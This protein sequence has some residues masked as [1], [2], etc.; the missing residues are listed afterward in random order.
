MIKV[1]VYLDGNEFGY[2]EF[3][4]DATI[5]DFIKWSNESKIIALTEY[6]TNKLFTIPITKY[7]VVVESLADE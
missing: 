5:Q 6:G 1:T 4:S 2:C 7:V 3:K